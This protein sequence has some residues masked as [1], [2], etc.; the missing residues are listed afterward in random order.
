[1]GL[2]PTAWH[3]KNNLPN[4]PIY[5]SERD[6]HSY[7]VTYKKLQIKLRKFFET[8][9]GFKPMTFATGVMLYQLSYEASLE[10]SLYH[11]HMTSCYLIYLDNQWV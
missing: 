10:A 7:E 4:Y 9:T 6:P 2:Q 1:M 5:T 3:S 11:I 8:P